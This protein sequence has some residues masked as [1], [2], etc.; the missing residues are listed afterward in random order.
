MPFELNGVHV[1]L[2]ASAKGLMTGQLNGSMKNSYVQSTLIPAIAQSLTAQ[3]QADPSSAQSRQV[4]SIF[5][6]GGCT[7]P[8]GSQARASDFTISTCEV[9]Q[10]SVIQN[11]L[12]PDVQIYDSQGRYAPNPANTTRD[13]LSVGFAFTAVPA[14]Y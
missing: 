11:L 6:T 1:Q 9:A 2:T 5:D 12:A 13:S 10:N 3:V 7:N 4:E 8:D 14:R